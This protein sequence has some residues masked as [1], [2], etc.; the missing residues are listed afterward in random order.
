MLVAVI[1]AMMMVVMMVV[2]TAAT[3]ATAA[4]CMVMIMVAM[5]AATAS[6]VLVLMIVGIDE[7]RCKAPLQSDRL[8]ARGVTR[9]NGERHH[10][11]GDADIVNLPEIVAAQAALAIEDEQCRGSLQLVSV[12]GFG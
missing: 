6:L 10:L 9:L 5:T 1:V 4:V 2:M 11:G 8:V 7:D 12:H 3:T